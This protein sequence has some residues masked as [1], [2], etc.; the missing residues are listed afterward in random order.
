MTAVQLEQRLHTGEAMIVA[1]I[2]EAERER[3]EAYWLALLRQY[4]AA[5]E[6]ERHEHVQEALG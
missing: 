3:L 2:S 4:V 6:A 1:A 5:C